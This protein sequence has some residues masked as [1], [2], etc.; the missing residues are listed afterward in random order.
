MDNTKPTFTLVYFSASWNPTCKAIEKDYQNT[1]SQYQGFEH[2]KVDCDA[3]PTVKFYFDARVEPQ[4]MI[5][6]NGAEFK[7]VIGYNFN[8]LHD[9]LD[10]VVEL[11]RKEYQY[12]GNTGN[13][14]ER[15]YDEFD[16]WSRAGEYD[17]DATRIYYEPNTDQHRGPGSL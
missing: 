7:R 6:L 11:H 13:Q 14:W 4:F 5:L 8:R 17:K 10:Q 3:T 15:F 12:I 1:C 2:I 16:R 9:T